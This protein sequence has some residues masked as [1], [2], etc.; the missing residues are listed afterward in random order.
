[1]KLKN[2]FKV[3]VKC[4][5]CQGRRTATTNRGTRSDIVTIVTIVYRA[6]VKYITEV[7][8]KP[9][10]AG[11]K[12]NVEVHVSIRLPLYSF[13]VAARSSLLSESLKPIFRSLGPDKPKAEFKGFGHA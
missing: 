13:C 9:T 1:M 2:I 10:T 7:R 6:Y 5:F 11:H 4:G 12:A 3:S 8:L